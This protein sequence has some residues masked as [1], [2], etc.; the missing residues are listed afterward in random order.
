M[1][2]L[3]IADDSA[4]LRDRLRTLIADL[5]FVELVGQAGDAQ[6]AIKE[7]QK[8]EP[9]VLILDIRMPEGN[10]S[11]VLET[12]DRASDKPK[13]VVIVLTA[14]PYPQ[15]RRKYLKAGA[16]YFFDKATEFE[17]VVTVLE[18]LV[19]GSSDLPKT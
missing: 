4:L 6:Q 5:D 1:L 2:K 14:Y 7:I 17:C 19:E 3:Y 12:L 10:G 15:Y 11:L 16:D 8:L 13:P 9:D 18:Q